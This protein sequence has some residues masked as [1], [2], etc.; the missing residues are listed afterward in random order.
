MVSNPAPGS[1]P[2]EESSFLVDRLLA[3]LGRED[4]KIQLTRKRPDRSATRRQH[5]DF[6]RE[7]K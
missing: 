2:M 3:R 6:L 5:V 7:A 1:R 4:L